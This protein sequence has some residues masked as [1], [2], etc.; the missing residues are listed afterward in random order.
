MFGVWHQAIDIPTPQGSDIHAPADGIVIKT[1]DGGYGYSYLVLLHS[2]GAESMTTVYGHVSKFYV[3][4]GQEVKRGDVIAAS[5]ATPGTP[6]AGWMTTG[7]HLHFEVRINGVP[8]D[9]LNY[10]P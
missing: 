10:L 1:H 2:T 3:S 9:P 4:V 5:G 7:P 6:G 8:Q